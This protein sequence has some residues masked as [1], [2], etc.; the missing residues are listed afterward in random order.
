MPVTRV[1]LREAR[2]VPQRHGELKKR[3]IDEWREEP[4]PEPRPDIVEETEGDRTVHIYV[5]WDDWGTLSQEDRSE[6]I[7][8]AYEEAAGPQKALEVTV[9]MGLSHRE[10][11]RM[12][13][14]A[15]RQFPTLDRVRPDDFARIVCTLASSRGQR[16]SDDLKALARDLASYA[17]TGRPL[18]DDDAVRVAE[19]VA[20]AIGYTPIDKAPQDGFG[21][22]LIG[23][24]ARAKLKEGSAVSRTELYVLATLSRA[25]RPPIR[26]GE[27]AHAD[28]LDYLAKRGIKL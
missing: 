8:D 16:D 1:G 12:G 6:I 22:V 13:I 26:D 14:T 2:R 19:R 17:V 25:S 4:G 15:T 18:G 10:A 24:V 28:A 3:L 27:V 21:I 5:T 7:M 9:A 11:K 20:A 23:A